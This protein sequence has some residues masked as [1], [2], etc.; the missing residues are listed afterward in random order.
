MIVAF[1]QV[2]VKVRVAK[3]AI[4]PTCQEFEIP[5]LN[6]NFVTEKIGVRT[7]RNNYSRQAIMPGKDSVVASGPST[8][9]PYQLDVDQ[10]CPGLIQFVDRG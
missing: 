2:W 5:N 10:V 1:Q 9:S 3:E 6:S 4:Y 8:Q 7:S